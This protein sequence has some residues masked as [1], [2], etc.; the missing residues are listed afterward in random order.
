MDINKYYENKQDR[1]ERD[2]A[3]TIFINMLRAKYTVNY[4]HDVKDKTLVV[5]IEKVLGPKI[6]IIDDIGCRRVYYSK[7]NYIGVGTRYELEEELFEY[8]TPKELVDLIEKDFEVVVAKEV[9]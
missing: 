4:Q 6:K 3:I 2:E 9:E 1:L 8:F 5:Y 7:Y